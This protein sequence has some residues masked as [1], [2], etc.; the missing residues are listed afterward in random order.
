MTA[1]LN[2]APLLRLPVQLNSFKALRSVAPSALSMTG[3]KP[4]L[5]VGADMQGVFVT[6]HGM[7]VRRFAT[8]KNSQQGGPTAPS[9]LHLRFL[10]G[11]QCPAK[12][13]LVSSYIFHLKGILI[14]PENVEDSLG[15]GKEAQACPEL[16]YY[17]GN[18][19]LAEMV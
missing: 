4:I 11:S 9:E 7:K 1:S 10:L 14:V 2:S 3:Y 15:F 19:L 16:F 13:P 6:V 17:L 5:R 18:L 12:H 8:G